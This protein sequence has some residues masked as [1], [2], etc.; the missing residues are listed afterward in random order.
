MRVE[1]RRQRRSRQRIT[2]E[3]VVDGKG[4]AGIVIDHSPTEI[5]VQTRARPGLDSVL[6]L[7]L[8]GDG[9]SAEIRCEAGVARER[10]TPTHLQTSAPGGI[11][12]ELIDPPTELF[13]LLDAGAVPSEGDDRAGERARGARTFRVR[14]K[15]RGRPNSRVITVRC[16]SAQAARARALRQ[17]GAGWQVADIRE[18]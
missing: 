13:A 1:K 15:E 16:E 11:G 14:V 12:L 2:C 9:A 10:V 17:A 6:E 3:L 7:V 5:F 18:L 8:R 4:Y